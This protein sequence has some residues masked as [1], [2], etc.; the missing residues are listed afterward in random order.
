MCSHMPVKSILK[1]SLNLSFSDPPKTLFKLVDASNIQ[2]KTGSINLQLF[3]S[4]YCYS[5]TYLWRNLSYNPSL[6]S[7]H[8]DSSEKTTLSIYTGWDRAQK[9][10]D[11]RTRA[12]A[13]VSC[14]PA[15]RFSKWRRTN[16]N[17]TRHSGR[18][19]AAVPALRIFQHR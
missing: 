2:I 10:L 19:Q 12:L 4:F 16:Q 18:C 5:I 1:W 11:M 9:P 6:R 15:V 14:I 3:F 13:T 17:L 8:T 7:T